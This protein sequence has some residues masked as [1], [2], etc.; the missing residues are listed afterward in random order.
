MTATGSATP[1]P[2]AAID[3]G[4]NTVRL[5]VARPIDGGLETVLDRSEFIRLGFGLERTGLLDP[6]REERA[7]ATLGAFAEAARD[8]GAET[9]IAMA[10][11]AVREARNGAEFVR[12]ARRKRGIEVEIVSGEEE[13]RLTYLGATLGLPLDGPALVVDLGGGSGE[14]IGAGEHGLRWGRS[15]P[16]GSGRLTEQFVRHD[17]PTA[18]ELAAV[19]T[20]VAT[21]VAPLPPL[22]ARQAVF[23]GGSARW[24]AAVLE[25]R[26]EPVRL[27]P[28]DLKE[29]VQV[30]STAPA[31]EIAARYGVEPERAP[32]LPAGIQ[33]L[34]AIADHY[35]V[36]EIAVT[37][38]GIRQGMIL[39]LL[40]RQGHPR[41]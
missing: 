10:T 20:A 1:P 16:I 33:A 40:E 37:L 26:G 17:P 28:A 32:A 24:L 7:L 14:I 6:A 29:A 35:Q 23:T 11:S 30:V 9:V 18:D 41:Q 19:A 34:R 12:R 8:A 31:A 13:A 22:G 39:E 27:T 3:I 36:E 25:R 2:V 38:N 21:A 5:L 4:S 15:L